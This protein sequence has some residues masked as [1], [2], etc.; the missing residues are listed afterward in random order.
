MA[1]QDIAGMYL[2]SVALCNA[3]KIRHTGKDGYCLSGGGP[4]CGWQLAD[5][6]V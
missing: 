2:V 6:P 5:G 1:L 3:L 4:N